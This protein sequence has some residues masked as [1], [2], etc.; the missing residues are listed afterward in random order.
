MNNQELKVVLKMH[1][2]EIIRLRWFIFR[3]N[4]AQFIRKATNR[5]IDA[6]YPEGKN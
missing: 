5:L 1:D 6:I 2:D 4:V 3:I